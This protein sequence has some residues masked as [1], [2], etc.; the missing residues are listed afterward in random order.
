[1]AGSNTRGGSPRLDSWKAIA[2]F[3]GRTVRTV[4]RWE[5]EERLP[6]HRHVHGDG[7]SVYAFPAEL[8]RWRRSR[9]LVPPSPLSADPLR[10]AQVMSNT[11]EL[12]VAAAGV[13]VPGHGPEVEA[14]LLCWMGLYHWTHRT[15]EGFAR[16]V[17]LAR[18]AVRIVPDFALGLG[19]I[20][21]IRATEA[22]YPL[23]RP[24]PSMRVARRMAESAIRSDRDVRIGH[25][26]LGMVQLCYE[27]R[28]EEAKASFDRAHRLDRQDATTLQWL[29]LWML[30]AGRCAEAQA[31]S[32]QAER[33]DPTTRLLVVHA[34]WLH[35]MTGD[36][37][38]AV[39]RASALVRRER[40]A[41]DGYFTLGLGLVAL[42]RFAEADEAFQMASA[43]SDIPV[44]AALRAHALA[45]QGRA[46]E[47]RRLMQRLRRTPRYIPRYWFAYGLLGMGERGAALDSLEQALRER[48]W[49]LLFLRYDPAFADLR[50]EPRFRRVVAPVPD[51]THI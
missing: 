22:T 23:V 2:A 16:G 51:Q 26:A 14:A 41:W 15:T 47:A 7:A 18:R 11:V 36:A 1:M 39:E 40:H 46:R 25:Q 29:S 27:W 45:R 50:R 6:V 42:G 17:A 8:D 34:A 4:Q 13:G 21:L 19:L 31:I 43:L 28:L 44:V 32:Q 49:W 35:L 24:G 20:A 3:L 9:T 37:D 38:G 48:E 5:R 12:A 10:F 30:A 33:F